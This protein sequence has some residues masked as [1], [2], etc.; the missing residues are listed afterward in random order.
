MRVR[1][2]AIRFGNAAGT[3]KTPEEI[4]TILSTS[5]NEA[6]FG[7]VTKEPRTG[8]LGD[9][10]YFNQETGTSYNSIGL[11]NRGVKYAEEVIPELLKET[12]GDAGKYLIV[13]VAG[14]TVEETVELADRAASL[15]VSEVEINLGCPNVWSEEGKQKPIPS[16]HP[17]LFEETLMRVRA[18]LGAYP[19]AAKIS[20]VSNDLLRKL[21]PIMVK[22]GHPYE[23]GPLRII[24][25]NTLPNRKGVRE[26]NSDAL[27]FRVSEESEWQNL[28]GE[29]GAPLR[30]H[31]HRVTKLLLDELPETIDIVVH[32][33]ILKP[34]DAKELLELG[35]DGFGAATGFLEFGPR[36]FDDLAINLPEEYFL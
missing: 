18:R 15:G 9:V 2:T 21:I 27:R 1:G 26:D 8:N 25:C 23:K 35:A 12:F 6:R 36:F 10:Y 33:G 28:G 32:G 30:P 7:S 34:K 4:R 17:E 29:A 20:P 14:F 3:A 13:S 11:S 22:V 16:Y 31:A 24:G 19:I 5:A